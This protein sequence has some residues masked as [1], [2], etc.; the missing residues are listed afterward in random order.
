MVGVPSSN[1]G[2][3]WQTQLKLGLQHIVINSYGQW[4]FGHLIRLIRFVCVFYL[5]V[6]TLFQTISSDIEI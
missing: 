2:K 3:G 5:N 4:A 6:I 1:P